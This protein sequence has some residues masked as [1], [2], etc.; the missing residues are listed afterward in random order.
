MTVEEARAAIMERYGD[1]DDELEAIAAMS[2]WLDSVKDAVERATAAEQK[3]EQ[4]EKEWRE[5][6][7][8]RFGE[9]NEN[10]GEMEKD[11]EP[12]EITIDEFIEKMRK[13][14]E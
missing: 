14:D 11:A 8:A 5:K 3:L 7:R 6:Y 2:D 13:V 4:T 12:D 10:S 1:T 9:P